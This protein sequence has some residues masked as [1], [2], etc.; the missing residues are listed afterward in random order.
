MFNLQKL[1]IPLILIISL[2]SCNTA[3]TTKPFKENIS[4]TLQ[5]MWNNTEY[6]FYGK[7]QDNSK[8]ILKILSPE[9]FKDCE[10]ILSGDNISFDYLGLKIEDSIFNLQP[11]SPFRCLAKGFN[12]AFSEETQTVLKN[13][14][15]FFTFKLNSTDYNFYFG[16][17]GLPIE[18]SEKNENNFLQFKNVTILN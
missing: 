8:L 7:T 18:I 10:V 14:K 5:G 13:D 1:V 11:E 6:S 15:I 9:R 2:C 12:T 17:T 4:F 3:N 16:A